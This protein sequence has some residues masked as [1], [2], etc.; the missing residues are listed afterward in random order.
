MVSAD[1]K[2]E[3]LC[4]GKPLDKPYVRQFGG[5]LMGIKSIVKA[6]APGL[7]PYF[8]TVFVFTSARVDANW[9]TT[10]N[11][12]CIR[13]G[14]LFK[15]IV[16]GKL[17][18]KLTREDVKTIAQPFLGQAHMDTDFTEKARRNGRPRISAIVQRL[19][20]RANPPQD[21][22]KTSTGGCGVGK[23]N[24]LFAINSSFLACTG[25]LQLRLDLPCS[26]GVISTQGLRPTT[27]H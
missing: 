16:E 18:G 15:Y 1:G 21:R 12:H 13:D 4:N 10:G 11:L 26:V 17:G 22:P 6:L 23:G 25:L 3:L 14:H 27:R 9:A 5:Q 7:D 24:R 8:K 20:Q 2:G 19:G